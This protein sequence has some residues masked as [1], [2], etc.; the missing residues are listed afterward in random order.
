M[1]RT[2]YD[3]AETSDLGK[4]YQ[5]VYRLRCPLFRE[6]EG[7]AAVLGGIMDRLTVLAERE[8]DRTFRGA[9]GA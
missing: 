8:D 3:L 7:L 1:E 6:G 4:A 5:D 2:D 9:Y